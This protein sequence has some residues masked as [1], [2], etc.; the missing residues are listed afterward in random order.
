MVYINN[1]KFVPHPG[2]FMFDPDDRDRY[3]RAV[4]PPC[5]G[6]GRACLS[7][8]PSIS[9]M[10]ENLASNIDP[11]TKP[12]GLKAEV[13]ETVEPDTQQSAEEKAIESV[14]EK[15]RLSTEGKAMESTEEKPRLSAEGKPILSE[16]GKPRLSA[17]GKPRLSA[18]GKPR[19]SAEGKP[20]LS[21][22]GKTILTE[23]GKPRL[24]AEGKPRLSAEGKPIL[25][26]EGKP[27]LS[28]EGKPRLSAEG[29][30]RESIKETTTVRF[31]EPVEPPVT[32][33]IYGMDVTSLRRLNA[34][35]S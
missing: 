17:E 10:V 24:S 27:R 14:E 33:K 9:C 20:R 19:L 22:E 4:A 13:K 5:A 8:Y 16:E 30:A 28:A 31:E 35:E 18:E 26:E 7:M 34:Q 2:Y 15:P 1:Y 3:G 25:T 23:E 6:R 29:K 21:A 11:G 32:F 12:K